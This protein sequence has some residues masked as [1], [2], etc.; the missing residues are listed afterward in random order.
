MKFYFYILILGIGCYPTNTNAQKS[1]FE[2]SGDI[3]EYAF[4][5]IAGASTL[6]WKDDKKGTLQFVK[7]IGSALV[8]AYTLKKVI[9]KKRPDGFNY[10]FPSGH[11]TSAFA[12]A[13]FMER[14]YG[15]EV[16]IPAYLLAGY[17][18]WT[19]VEANRHDYWDVLGGA[20]L[21]IVSAYIF[22]KP[23]EKPVL[24][25]SYGKYKEYHMLSLNYT[26]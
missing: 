10:A 12:S 20:T 3:L 23:Y 21:G 18:G 2:K 14:R 22:A 11:T 19:R 1:G 6:I 5:A 25:I 13:A 4:P 15:L 7:T 8:V 16:G 26:F 9:N 17:V 24:D